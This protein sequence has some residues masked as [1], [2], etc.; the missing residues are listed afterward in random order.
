MTAKTTLTHRTRTGNIATRTTAKAYSHVVETIG[1]DSDFRSA[2][3]IRAELEYLK[4]DTANPGRFEAMVTRK[5]AAAEAAQAQGSIVLSWHGSA[6]L[7]ERAALA[8]HR[9][10]YRNVT[11]RAINPA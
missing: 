3:E 2:D 10:G 8:A 11:A 1:H 9:N 7:A 6:E 4:A 5:I